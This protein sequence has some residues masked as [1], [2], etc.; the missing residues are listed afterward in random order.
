MINY[1]GYNTIT[2]ARHESKNGAGGVAII[3]KEDI[4]FVEVNDLDEFNIEAVAIKIFL[5]KLEVIF[6]SYYNPPNATLSE[7]MFYS[8][9]QRY[10]N[11]IIC[12][13][14]NAK[15]KTLNCRTSNSNG[16][17]LENIMENSEDNDKQQ[18]KHVP[19]GA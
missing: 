11:I 9:N 5:N 15:S 14:L 6:V 10:E 3:I 19:Q 8:L 18:S 4:N 12:G 13:D 17:I 2:K 1:D 16:K 7:E